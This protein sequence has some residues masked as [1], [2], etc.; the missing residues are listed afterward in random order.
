M[1]KTKAKSRREVEHLRGVIRSLKKRLNQQNS[2]NNSTKKEQYEDH[3]E[4]DCPNCG[5]GV[6]VAKDF[7]HV[8]ILVCDVC[9]YREKINAKE[10]ES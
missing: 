5:K 10:E 2:N 6:L 8:K 7:V 4:S 1:G 9:D 3:P